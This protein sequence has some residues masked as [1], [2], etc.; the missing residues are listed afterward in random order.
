MASI[1]PFPS[2]RVMPRC[3]LTDSECAAVRS[4]VHHKGLE[5]RATG[6]SR[7]NDGQFMSV[8][9]RRGARYF[10]GREEGVCYLF[11]PDENQLAEGDRFDDVLAALDVALSP[12][13][14]RL[15][16]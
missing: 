12:P 3:A 11:D 7:H 2:H 4:I 14:L 13:S 15:A 6:V 10:V 8:F 9:D 16:T 5:G 1:I